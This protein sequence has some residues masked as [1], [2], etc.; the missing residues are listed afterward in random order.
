MNSVVNNTILLK[1]PYRYK[2]YMIKYLNLTTSEI[3]AKDSS[4]TFLE[5]EMN[6]VCNIKEYTTISYK[7]LSIDG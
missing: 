7:L 3:F 4:F 6:G 1:L 5:F 2:R